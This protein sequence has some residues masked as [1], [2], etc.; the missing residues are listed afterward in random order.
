MTSLLKEA[1][2]E[3]PKDFSF[4]SENLKKAKSI[5]E[6]YPKKRSAVMPLLH[7][8][9]EQ[10]QDNWISTAAMNYVAELLDM[11]PI[12]VYEV[13]NFYTMYNK[14][15]VGKNLIQLCRTT[16][17]WL[18]GSEEL[19]KTCKKK[20]GIDVG[21]TTEDNKFTLVEVECLGACAN[22]PIVQINNDYYEDLT[23]ESFETILQK[24]SKSKKEK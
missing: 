12:Q 24:L 21:E 1:N 4:T 2:F 16:P 14:Q 9:Q 5:I 19:K 23:P 8:A 13:A 3:Q 22:A 6:K 20:L 15:P 7:L 11:P 10:Q 18:R 17:C